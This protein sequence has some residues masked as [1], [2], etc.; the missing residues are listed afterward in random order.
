MLVNE[1]SAHGGGLDPVNVGDD[2]TPKTNQTL[3][4]ILQ[5]TYWLLP[6]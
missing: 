3:I 6:E 4:K 5:L 1:K 2:H